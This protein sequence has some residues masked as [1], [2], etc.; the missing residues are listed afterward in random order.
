MDGR[1]EGPPPALGDR[2]THS[3]LGAPRWRQGPGRDD[4]EY[5]TRSPKGPKN[6]GWKDSG[7]AVV[8]DDGTDAPAPLA[9]CELQGYWFA[10]QQLMAVMCVPLGHLQDARGFW[11]EAAALKARF[12]RD[13]W[14][15]DDGSIALAMDQGQTAHPRSHLEYRSLPGDGDR[16]R[17][18]RSP[19]GRTVVR[20][21]PVQRL[22][23]TD[24]FSCPSVL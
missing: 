15:N 21:G 13:W 2:T 11:R 5:Q 18:S 14:L 16:Q 22:G 12:N 7:D 9:T 3:R 17:R 1:D 20:A 19:P 8:Y 23:N 6:Q 4:L 10:A 24:F